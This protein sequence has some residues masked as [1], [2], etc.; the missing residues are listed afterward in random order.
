[1]ENPSA[2]CRTYGLPD[3]NH[4]EETGGGLSLLQDTEIQRVKQL[5]NGHSASEWGLESRSYLFRV[6]QISPGDGDPIL[7]A[8]LSYSFRREWKRAT[9]FNLDQITTSRSTRPQHGGVTKDTPRVNCL[10]RGTL[11]FTVV[12]PHL[13]SYPGKSYTMHT[14]KSH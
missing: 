3:H 7:T 4:T 9:F 14:R 12:C 13:S 10:I 1:M 5:A 6:G 8:T 11:L 2:L